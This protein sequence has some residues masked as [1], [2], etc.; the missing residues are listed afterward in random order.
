MMY[1]LLHES[2]NIIEKIL[3]VD[4]TLSVGTHKLTNLVNSRNAII[5]IVKILK[6]NIVLFG[7][8]VI[9]FIWA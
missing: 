9:W 2:N 6:M 7:F 8:L 1:F 3:V 5:I 4:I